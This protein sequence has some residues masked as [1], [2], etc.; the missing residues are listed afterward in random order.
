MDSE[1]RR[2]MNEILKSI[3]D[4][5]ESFEQITTEFTDWVYDLAYRKGWHDGYWRQDVDLSHQTGSLKR[6]YRRRT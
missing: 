6:R 1:T 2:K 4:E 5:K 3:A